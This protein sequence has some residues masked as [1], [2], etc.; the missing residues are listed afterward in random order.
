MPVFRVTRANL[1]VLVKPR[2][3]SGFLEKNMCAY[4]TL[5]VQTRYPKHTRNKQKSDDQT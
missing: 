1:N 3:F 4:P 5:N 2:F